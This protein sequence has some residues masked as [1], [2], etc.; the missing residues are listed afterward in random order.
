M[1]N[2]IKVL[3]LDDDIHTPCFVTH[4][5]YFFDAEEFMKECLLHPHTVTYEVRKVSIYDREEHGYSKE[6]FIRMMSALDSCY[7]PSKLFA[8]SLNKWNFRE[9]SFE[10]LWDIGTEL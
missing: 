6:E 7:E 3:M 1:N 9:M 5:S 10:K 4:G 8:E 2:P